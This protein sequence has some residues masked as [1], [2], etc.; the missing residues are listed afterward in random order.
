MEGSKDFSDRMCNN[1]LQG[2]VFL[3][4]KINLKRHCTSYVYFY[5]YFLFLPVDF[6]F[7]IIA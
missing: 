6:E 3:F 7:L 1:E 5:L 4:P 2:G